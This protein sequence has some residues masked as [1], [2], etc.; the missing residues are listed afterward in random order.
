VLPALTVQHAMCR[1]M[2]LGAV[3]RA[4]QE[5]LALW[6]PMPIRLWRRLSEYAILPDLHAR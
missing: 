5:E 4:M 3:L 6:S 1:S 2:R